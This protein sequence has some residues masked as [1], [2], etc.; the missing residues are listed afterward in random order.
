MKIAV[1]DGR[2]GKLGAALVTGVLERHPQAELIAIGLNAVA[3][4]Q[5]RRAGARQVATGENPVTVACRRM[6]VLL[7]S[8][9]LAVP[10]SMSGEVTPTIAAAVAHS[11]AKK[12]LV[13]MHLEGIEVAGIPDVTVSMLIEDALRRIP[14]EAVR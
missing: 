5:M 11:E 13:P 6:D 8:L 10:D 12:I 9:E 4:E 14:S 3:T 2:G 1:I 7:C